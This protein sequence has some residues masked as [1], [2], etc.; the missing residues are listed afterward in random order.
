MRRV[1]A[2]KVWETLALVEEKQGG[3]RWVAPTEMVAV[4]MET[5]MVAVATATVVGATLME[6][7]SV[8]A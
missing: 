2:I 7:S 8:V 1:G 6:A 5:A 4:A 3:E